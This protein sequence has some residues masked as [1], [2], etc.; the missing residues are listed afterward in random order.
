MRLVPLLYSILSIL[1][2]PS[3]S[4]DDKEGGI[5]ECVSDRNIIFS[6]NIADFS[7]RVSQDGTQWSGKDKIGAFM[8][9]ADTFEP[10]NNSIN[11]PYICDS[12]GYTTTFTSSMPLSFP[13]DN[14]DVGFMAYY[15]Y[16]DYVYNYLYPIQLVNQERGSAAYDLMVGSSERELTYNSEGSARVALAF[17]HQLAKVIFKFVDQDNNFLESTQAVVVKGMQTM[18]TFDLQTSRL[19]PKDNSLTNITTYHNTATRSYEAMIL[20]ST[21]MNTYIV[22]FA[23]DGNPC[24]WVFT[25]TDINLPELQKGYKYT[26]TIPVDEG[27]ISGPAKVEKI[28]SGNS[29]SPWTDGDPASGMASAVN[30][31]LFPEN[32]GAFADTE[33]KI[34]FAGT[35][36][37]LG[38]K[39]YIRIYRADDNTLVDMIDMSERK[40]PIIDGVTKLNTWMDIVGV[41]P[42]ASTVSRRVVNYE[43]VRVEDNMVIIKPH[44]QRLQYNTLYYV[45][46]DKAAIKQ[47]QFNGI[48]ARKWLFAT[49]KKPEF[50]ATD[51]Y[52]VTV[53]H[54]NANADFY[55]LQGAIDYFAMNVER[56]VPKTIKLENGIY[57]EI[58]YL[59]DQDNITV[60]GEDRNKVSLQYDNRNMWNGGIG[61]GM[62]IDQFAPL[63]TPVNSG[64]RSVITIG[65]NSDKIRFE[66]MTIENTAG[67]NGQAEAIVIRNNGGA[68]A[69]IDC[70]FYGYQDTVLSGGGYNW[71]YNCLI[72]GATDFIWGC[73]DISLFEK[74]EI[75]AIN[76][77]RALQARVPKGKIGYIFSNCRFTVGEGIVGKTLLISSYAPDNIT[78]LNTTFSDVF[79]NN[80]IENGVKVEPVNP[81][82]QEGCK[83]Y[84]CTN[85]SGSSVFDLIPEDK[86]VNS[87]YNLNKTEYDLYF[88]S[89]NILLNG[90]DNTGGMWFK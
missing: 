45:T 7:T 75:R 90:Y 57:K 46:V 48:Y 60:K 61:E 85:E 68:T 10:L 29:S 89:R 8:Y 21:I 51:A 69:F 17:S 16:N 77:G 14:R 87:I 81:T 50:S 56:N 47:E 66:N 39:G 83:M 15:P 78:F 80:Y 27:K 55:T 2:L 38:T 18:G 71:F 40:V 30:Y 67:N 32:S 26:F 58:I 25:D 22:S 24:E 65:G 11:V 41:T 9:D 20:P 73:G 35:A 5:N 3:C 72:T 34:T 12:E 43:P 23:I 33:L 37:L 70:N 53:S 49:K 42:K 63:G 13:E 19:I 62:N 59:R 4:D 1:L 31:D 84:N 88:G 28:N 54:T 64:N 36:P 44:S 86:G 82:V 6:I 76:N 52:T 79:I 74:C